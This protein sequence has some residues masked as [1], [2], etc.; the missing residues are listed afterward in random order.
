MVPVSLRLRRPLPLQSCRVLL[1][2][3]RFSLGGALPPITVFVICSLAPRNHAVNN[4]LL[5]FSIG[6]ISGGFVFF[7]HFLVL[8]HGPNGESTLL[9]QNPSRGDNF[10]IRS[11]VVNV[12]ALEVSQKRCST[13]PCCMGRVVLFVLPMQR[14]HVKT[15]FD[16]TAAAR[17][18]L[19]HICSRPQREGRKS[20]NPVFQKP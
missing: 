6:S 3:H 14:G 13:A 2:N 7:F 9:V 19:S 1:Q 16:N 12:I 11:L 15:R 8:L 10:H 17:T 4:G 5:T 20:R 18:P